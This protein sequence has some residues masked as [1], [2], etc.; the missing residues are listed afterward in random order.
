MYL[1]QL[2]PNRF[3]VKSKIHF[4]FS[5]IFQNKIDLFNHLSNILIFH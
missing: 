2:V 3:I 5:N 4:S 1:P